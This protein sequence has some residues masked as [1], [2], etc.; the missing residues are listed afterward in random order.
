M[1]KSFCIR[2]W[3]HAMIQTDGDIKL[4][5]VSSEKSKH[6]LKTSTIKEWWAS[7][8]VNTVRQQMLNGEEPS[9]CVNCFNTEKRGGSS[10]RQKINKEYKF[11]ERYADKLINHFNYP[12]ES[13]ID[14]ELSLTNLCNLKCIMCREQSSSTIATE[15]KILKISKINQTDYNIQGPEIDKIKDL[16]LS[17]PKI[18]NFRGGE[19]FIVPEI[20]E[21]VQWALDND[22]LDDT[23]VHI[24]TNGTRL[25]N[26]WL[27]L[28]IKI[29][30]L[31]IMLS[32]DGIGPVNDYIRY[33]SKW[34]NI[35]KVAKQLSS[36]SG[37]NFV[38]HATVMNIN[39]LSI[40]DLIKWCNQNNYFLDVDLLESPNNFKID[41]FP[42]ALLDKAKQQLKG[43]NDKVSETVLNAI[44]SAVP[45]DIDA[46]VKEINMRDK[47]RQVSI[48]N[49]IP[50]LTPYWYDTN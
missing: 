40:P 12:S 28:L 21:L 25:T 42:V 34:E 26:E 19:T 45:K 33:G 3:T 11:I 15:N 47:I 37:V 4:C 27:D 41:V 38:I 2:P 46:L 22:L 49:V 16:I 6:N 23:L 24:T 43:M 8:F 31:R 9:S 39:V 36:I 48:L 13:P 44:E 18:L 29:K 7:E 32:V 5:C 20:K 35:E 17:K 1:S 30:H 14:I 10:I 50:D